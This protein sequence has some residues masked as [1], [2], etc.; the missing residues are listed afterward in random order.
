MYLNLNQG[1]DSLVA[2]AHQIFITMPTKGGGSSMNTFTRRCNKETKIRKFGFIESVDLK[3]L[4]VG[5]LQVKSVISLHVS[6]DTGLICLAMYPSQKTLMIHIHCEEGERVISGVK[7]ISHHMCRMNYQEDAPLQY[8]YKPNPKGDCCQHVYN[9][10]VITKNETH[11]ILDAESM[12]DWIAKG[13]REVGGGAHKLL[14]CKLYD[15]LQ[16]NAPQLVFLNYK[17]IDK[18][19]TLLAKHHCPELLDELPIKVNMA[20]DDEQKIYLYD[21]NDEKGAVRIEEWLD[22][23]GPVL[24]WALNLRSEASCQAKTI[25]MEDE[26]FGCPDEA[27]KV[28]PESIKKW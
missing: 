3:E 9:K 6:S 26:L 17:Q 23:K 20:T 12:V 2:R 19:Q 21:S 15:A 7:M 11:C 22:A 13:H 1:M 14:T 25:H 28:T 24:E 4:L 16:E 18:L 27:L 5:S 8:L 10:T